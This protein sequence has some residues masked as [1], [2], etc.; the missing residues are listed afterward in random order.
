MAVVQRKWAYLEP[1]FSRGALPSHASQF[2]Q[3]SACVYIYF[4][5]SCRRCLCDAYWHCTLRDCVS[6]LCSRC[7]DEIGNLCLFCMRR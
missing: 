4:R 2:R 3:V 7:P 5:S 6:A 1:I